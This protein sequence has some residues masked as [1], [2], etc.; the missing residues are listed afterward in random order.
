MELDSVSVE[1][2]I[3]N[4]ASGSFAPNWVGFAAG[5]L[6]VAS[7]L[8]FLWVFFFDQSAVRSWLT[9]AP[10]LVALA[11]G[12]IGTVEGRNRGLGTRV[13]LLGLTLGL[14]SFLLFAV[15]TYLLLSIWD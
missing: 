15:L 6:G 12:V 9:L 14:V 10:P 4:Q 11:F 3:D 8:W 7:I 5:V 2:N 13:A 1:L